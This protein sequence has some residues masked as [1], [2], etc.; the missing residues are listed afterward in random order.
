MSI[1]ITREQQEK[2][3]LTA[4]ACLA[5]MQ[6]EEENEPKEQTSTTVRTNRSLSGHNG[7]YKCDEDC[8]K[9]QLGGRE[10]IEVHH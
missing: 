8:G 9:C 7:I 5:L 1:S 3:R 2:E 6:V 10:E 4:E